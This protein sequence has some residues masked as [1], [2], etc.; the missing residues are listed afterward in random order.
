MPPNNDQIKFGWCSAIDREVPTVVFNPCGHAASLEVLRCG[1]SGLNFVVVDTLPGY[2]YY[3]E[4]VLISCSCGAAIHVVPQA[5]VLPASFFVLSAMSLFLESRLILESLH[6]Y[7]RCSTVV[8]V[9][10]VFS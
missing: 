10:V 9:V 8:V 4:I 1:S 7:V 2:G 6:M 3:V 5:S